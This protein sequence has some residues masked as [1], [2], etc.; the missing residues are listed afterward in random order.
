MSYGYKTTLNLD[1][2]S[3]DV[4]VLSYSFDKSIDE[5][6]KVTSPVEG[7]TIFLS[8]TDMPKKSILQWGIQYIPLKNGIIS[9]T[10]I[11]TES[12]VAD[13]EIVFENAACV[14]MKLVYERDH[15]NY[16]TT[17]LTISP[18]NICMG[19]SNCWINKE[20]TTEEGDASK[21]DAEA[22]IEDI[23]IPRDTAIDGFLYV[24]GKAY[25]IQS[26][27]TEFVQ[28]NDWKGQPQHQVKGGLLL[29]TLKQKTDEILNDWMFRPGVAYDGE[30]VF[31]P[32]SR[33]ENASLKISFTK[34]K[35]ISFEKMIGANVGIQIS[36]LI[37][38]EE[39]KVNEVKHTNNARK[40]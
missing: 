33:T 36:L 27:E 21:Q 15:S 19:R 12:P 11:D 40:I 3:H 28:E 24:N 4:T 8:L 22:A 10:G 18:Q 30:I 31:A 7:G 14:N 5:Y 32:I 9:T 29:I 39:I 26:F 13:E 34:G 6:G 1:G 16:F 2:F 37:S 23:F 17:L 20:W 38:P 35:C 25:E